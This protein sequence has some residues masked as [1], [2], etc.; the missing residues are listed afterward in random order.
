MY[1]EKWQLRL[2]FFCVSGKEILSRFNAE[3]ALAFSRG[4][5]VAALLLL[6]VKNLILTGFRGSGKTFFGRALARRLGLPFA[7]L[8]EQIE[9]VLGEPIAD[10]VERK[11]WQE[12][13]EVEQRV[14]HDFCRNFCGILA[15]GGGTIENSKNLQ[16]LKKAGKFVFLNPSFLQV[17]AYL[18]KDTTRPRILPELSLSEEITR[19][20]EQRKDI[21]SVT[22]DFEVSPDLQSDADGEVEKMLASFPPKVVPPTPEKKKIVVLT[23]GEGT[24]LQKLWEVQAQGR[25]PNVTICGIIVP[26]QHAPILDTA[27][28]HETCIT[29]QALPPYSDETPEEYDRQLVNVLRET[30]P[31]IVL[32][33]GWEQELSSVYI[34]QYGARSIAAIPALESLKEGVSAQEAF[35]E[36]IE[37]EERYSGA[38]FFR[39]LGEGD[40]MEEALQ[41]KIPIEADET[42]QT[43]EQKIERQIVLGFCELLEARK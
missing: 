18:M 39:L 34:E 33:S 29:R 2:I 36:S 9:F 25:I 14:T 5:Y 17:K 42:V 3:S 13:R 38:T 20:W 15:T 40:S 7:D 16:N 43:L 19:L 28:A 30:D 22:A 41:R 21:Y 6:P 31:D 8:D 27:Q 24:V 1:S 32:L 23:H 12:F 35:H 10:F 37:Q 11:G 26:Q 4:I